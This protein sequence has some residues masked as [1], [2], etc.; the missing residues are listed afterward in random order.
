M[1]DGTERLP[2]FSPSLISPSSFF[3]SGVTSTWSYLGSS[4]DHNTGVCLCQ[5]EQIS[6]LP[7]SS[8][9]SAAISSSWNMQRQLSSSSGDDRDGVRFQPLFHTLSPLLPFQCPLSPFFVLSHHQ[10]IILLAKA[11][12]HRYPSVPPFLCSS[13]TAFFSNLFSSITHF[14]KKGIFL[15]F[16]SVLVRLNFLADSKIYQM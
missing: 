11:Y 16:Y 10:G 15:F 14:N 13:F 4:E 5:W 9:C 6:V 12:T 3:W 2:G 7:P 1:A 8:Q